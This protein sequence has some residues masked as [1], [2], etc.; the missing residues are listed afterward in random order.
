MFVPLLV[1]AAA[2]AAAEAAAA[3]GILNTIGAIGVLALGNQLG[4][5]S[6]A[7]SPSPEP[8]P[9]AANGIGGGAANDPS[10][11]G[12]G[13]P[14]SDICKKL[15]R[16]IDLALNTYYS[17]RNSP[18]PALKAQAQALGQGIGALIR[19]Y[20]LICRPKITEVPYLRGL[21]S[22]KGPLEDFY[23]K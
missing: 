7:P 16:A 2:E 5:L 15:K 22:A 6:P 10:F 3:E 13:C 4:Q 21:P 23:L 19:Q 11:G 1:A 9:G 14:P 8:A 20:N 12:G 17:Y 18:D